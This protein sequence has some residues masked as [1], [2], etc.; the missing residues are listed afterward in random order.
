[1]DDAIIKKVEDAL[2]KAEINFDCLRAI[3][4]ELNNGNDLKDT[5]EDLN[6]YNNLNERKKY[7]VKIQLKSETFVTEPVVIVQKFV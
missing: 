7:K 3:C 6:I 4:F 1:M 2:L 5:L